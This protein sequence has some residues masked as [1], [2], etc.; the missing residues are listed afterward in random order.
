MKAT[1]SRILLGFFL[2]NAFCAGA[3][4]ADGR[5]IVRV[6]GGSPLL[7]LVC[8]LLGCSVGGGLDGSLGQVFLVTNTGTIP[9]NAFL[10]TLLQ[11]TGVVDGEPD[12]I[13][14]IA[15]SS[16]TVPP[17]LYDS[18]PVEYFGTTVPDGYVH[19][20]A[21]Q[22]VRLSD[23]QTTFGVKGAGTVAII[24]TGIDPNHPTLRNVLVPGYDFTRNQSGEG[25]ETADVPFSTTPYATPSQSS[26]TNSNSSA[27]VDQSTVA[28]VDGNPEYGDFGHGTMV[29][30]VIHLVAP[31]ASLMP[32]KAFRS[33]GTGYTSDII[34]ATYWAVGMARTSST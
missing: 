22:I 9:N 1:S 5:Y 20:P 34:R 25:D 18:A 12:L 13:G 14:S 17:A 16:Y 29:A 28:V 19:Q 26:W 11:E 2:L 23:T 8:T 32:L 30:G 24:D 7:Q 33:D 31:G 4:K 21:T 6:S 10:T 3:A 15:S 27:L